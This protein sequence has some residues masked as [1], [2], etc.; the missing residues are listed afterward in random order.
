M[1]DQLNIL[2]LEPFYGGIRKSMLETLTRRSRHRWTLLKLPPRRIDRRL[3]AAAQW[4]AEQLARHW[5]GQLDLLFTSE[6]LNL[7]D[8]V[9]LLPMLA[10]KPSVVYFHANELPDPPPSRITSRDLVN[11]ATAQ[12]ASELWF[13][14]NFHMENFGQRASALIAQHPELSSHDPVPE[15]LSKSRLMPPPIDLHPKGD[16]A[17]PAG[18]QR[19]QQT[20]FVETRDADMR[21]LNA[22]LQNLLQRGQKFE[23]V[24]VGPVK[25]LSADVSRTTLPEWDDL[26]HTAA[27]FQA[28]VFLSA[29]RAAAMDHFAVRAIAAHCWPVVP[30]DGFYREIIP[31]NLQER[32]LYDGTPEGL[33][34]FV[35]DAWYL[36]LPES[37]DEH[38]QAALKQYD[39]ATVCRAMDNR[40]SEVAVAYALASERAAEEIPQGQ[41]GDSEVG[42]A[43]TVE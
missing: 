16:L 3:A 32:C 31:Q 8:L 24:T 35:Q 5:V 22:G 25:E 2:A 20:I 4:F 39:P 21:L 28:D 42:E 15:M 6:A 19:R 12:V 40:L 30:A 17:A 33:A 34:G 13:N 29:R 37:A 43:E 9:R 14:S 23:L 18:A 38:L 41:I 10:Q 7:A 27:M 11:L 1:S 36:E 26:A